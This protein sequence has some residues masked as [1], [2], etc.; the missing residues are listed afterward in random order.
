MKNYIKLFVFAAI[1]IASTNVN[2]QI[3]VSANLGLASNTEDPF[4]SRRQGWGADGTL[5]LNLE[6]KYD[7]S[8]ALRVGASAGYY[9]K[10]R[11][12]NNYYYSYGSPI[13]ISLYAMPICGLVEYSFSDGKFSPYA[14]AN[15]GL[16]I[17][18]ERFDD[19]SDLSG[20]FGLAPVVGANYS[21]SDNL[22]INAN[23]KY[24]YVMTE[25]EASSL[26]SINGGVSFFL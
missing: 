3:S 13:K 25:G 2:A 7:I 9:S 10:S 23:A 26:Y 14:G 18:G 12:V 5:G 21:L 4:Y 8:D 16:Y 15:F 17:F 11:T 22:A 6:V 1:M 24:H 19:I 20:Y